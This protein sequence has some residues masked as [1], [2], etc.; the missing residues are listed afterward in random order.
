MLAEL[1]RIT[2]YYEQQDSSVRNQVLQEISLQVA[3]NERIAIVGPS[4]SGKSTLLNILGTLDKPSSGKVLLEGVAV[5][6]MRETQ[7][8]DLRNTFIGFVFQ[9]HHLLPQLTLFENVMLPVLPQKDMS[10]SKAAGERAVHLIER[11]GLKEH[12]RQYPSQLSVGECQRAAV[13]RALINQPRLLLADEPTGSL[14]AA[15][16]EKLSTLLAELNR[17]QNVAM[18]I[19]THSMELAAKMDKI[20]QLRE[21]RLVI[22]K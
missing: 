7:L 1:S 22:S 17:E 15:S 14:D 4:G 21:G 6:Q 19:V 10:A 16:A 12:M 20:Y 18:V 2:K 11:V 13:V 9:M 5:D 3:N 8:A